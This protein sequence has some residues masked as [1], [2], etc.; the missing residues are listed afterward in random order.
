[1]YFCP[2]YA[3]ARHD[4]VTVAHRLISGRMVESHQRF[5]K[6]KELEKE[7]ERIYAILGGNTANGRIL[8]G[9][10]ETNKRAEQMMADLAEETR[11]AWIQLGLT[12]YNGPTE[13]SNR[14]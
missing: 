1:M 8:G 5:L 12:E 6:H 11:Q 9:L 2:K 3:E 4:Q 13:E 10:L 14:E 7:A